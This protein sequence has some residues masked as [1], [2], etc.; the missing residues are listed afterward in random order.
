MNRRTLIFLLCLIFLAACT[1]TENIPDTPSVPLSDCQLPGGST[2]QCG[3]IVV[4]ENRTVA[5]GRTLSIHFAVIPAT[6]SITAPDPIFMLAGGPGQAASEAYPQ[7]LP[8]L[9]ALS[10]D[11][12]IVLIDQ[13]GTGQSHPL[14]CPSLSDLAIDASDDEAYAALTA[15]RETLAATTDLTQYTTDTAMADLDEVRVALGYTQINLIGVSYGTRAAMAYLRLYPEQ[16][17][18]MVLDAI[19]SPDLILQMQAPR[20]AERA[21]HLFFT[22]CTNDTACHAQ[23]PD[24]EAEFTSLRS[25]LADEVTV[26]FDHPITGE[27]QTITLDQDTFMQSIFNLL[28]SPDLISLLPLLIH[29]TQQTGDFGP[30]MA[31]VIAFSNSLGIYDGMFYAV[32]CSE[33]AALIDLTEAA[34][35][36]ADS[37]FPL[38]ADEFVKACA[39]WPQT[40]VSNAL[41]QP[42]NS[43]V[44][45]LLLSGEADPITPPSY[46]AE[47]AATLSNSQHLIVPGYGHGVLTIG[48]MPDIVA[49]FID[50]GTVVGLDTS[51]LAKV[52]P[53][54]F[55]ITPAGP[56]P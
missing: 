13:R 24:L 25:R 31:Q 45:T 28:Y 7:I 48:C 22:R 39:D 32:T 55:F 4:P 56:N 38:M 3:S 17:R 35:L 21:L 50:S 51:C 10:R 27:R 23:F 11:R 47:V 40:A 20:D 19:V 36:Q 30:L 52:Q 29:E 15:C 12:D 49:H 33:D 14:D 6:S 43:P 9:V 5:N 53:P 2:A 18:S 37:R 44:S 41:R 54:P 8:A 1:Q 46:A 34:A 16:V 42:V 26:T